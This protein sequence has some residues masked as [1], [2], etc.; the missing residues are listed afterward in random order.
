MLLIAEQ[1]AVTA[2]L[3]VG[4]FGTAAQEACNTALPD[5]VTRFP[6]VCGYCGWGV[7]LGWGCVV[8]G[9]GVWMGGVDGGCGLGGGICLTV[10]GGVEVHVLFVCCYAI[11]HRKKH[12]HT[13]NTVTEKTQNHFSKA[14]IML[15]PCLTS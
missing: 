5:V 7:W 2:S 6:R 11:A 14:S 9:W 1:D 3:T 10:C 13:H 4:Q 12:T 15:I 8:C